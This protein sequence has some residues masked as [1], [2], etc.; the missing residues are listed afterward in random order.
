MSKLKVDSA[1]RLAILIIGGGIGGVAT[2]LALGKQGRRVQLFEQANQIGAI[3][4]GVEIGP[5]VMPMPGIE[6]PLTA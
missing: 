3:G 5:N 1:D 6:T 2:A 4:Y